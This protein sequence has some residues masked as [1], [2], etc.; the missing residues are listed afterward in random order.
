MLKK[1]LV[2]FLLISL[3]SISA[4]K[5][6]GKLNPFPHKS[7]TAA[8]NGDTLRILAVMVNFQE[9][10][11]ASTFGNGKFGSIYTQ[12]YGTKILDPLPHDKQYFESHLEFTK[13]YF[14]KVSN[15]KLN[16]T[17][18]VLPDTL[19]VS[20]VMK[21]YTTLSTSTDFTPIGNFT[22][23]VWNLADQHYTTVNFSG[24][25]LFRSEEHTS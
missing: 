19:T 7:N 2:F 10:N 17:Y 16:I 22:S 13:N 14:R 6:S 18:N 21:N 12:N 3:G 8:F 4:Q 11:D 25:D 9:D 20:G 15:G 1:L 23:E 24:Y 5:Y